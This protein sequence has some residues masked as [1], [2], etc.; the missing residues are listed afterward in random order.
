MVV[1][2]ASFQS[3]NVIS[4]PNNA[5][6]RLVAEGGLSATAVLQGPLSLSVARAAKATRPQAYFINCCFPDVVN[7][8]MS[9]RCRAARQQGPCAAE[10]SLATATEEGSPTWR[11]AR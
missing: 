5:W 1:Q 6:T 10:P 9:E 8:R 7:P 11:R 2:A 3:G 4:N